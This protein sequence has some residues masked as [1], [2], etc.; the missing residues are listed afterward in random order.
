MKRS[1]WIEDLV[2]P[3][4]VATLTA[5]WVGL[6]VLWVARAGLPEVNYPPVSPLLLGLLVF[7]AALLTRVSLERSGGLGPARL[8]IVGAGLA[9]IA[10]ALWWTFR[11]AGIGAFLVALGDWGQYIS[12]VLM[13]LLAC[14]FMWWQGIQLAVANWPQ[15][16]LER[17]FGVGVIGLALL[18]AVNQ[19]NP[20]IA[21]GEAV[22][23]TVA[24]FGAGLG[25]LAL[26][27]FENA[28]SY[29]EGATGTRL[30]LNRY[31][32]ITIASVIG[33]ILAAGLVAA[34]LF[35]PGVYDSLGRATRGLLD[36]LT[37]VVAYAL[38]VL[39]ALV[40]LIVFPIMQALLHF[41]RPGAPDEIIE[42]SNSGT[43]TDQADQ[44]VQ[45]FADNPGLAAARQILFFVLLLVV[46]GLVLW[47]SVRR[48][49]QLNRRDSDEVRDSIATPELLWGQLKQFLN[50]RK[51]AAAEV[52]PYLALAGPGDDPRLIVRRAYQAMLEWARTVT[53]SRA[54]GQTPASYGEALARA[55]P[56]GRA[57]IHTLTGAYER[58]RYGAEPP[59]L[60]EARTA[61]G[62]LNELQALQT[63]ASNG[64]K[65]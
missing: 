14:A 26:V 36:G 62:A 50:R 17:S 39:A 43:V 46:V 13:A 32:L 23:T 64:S 57:A 59:S 56:Q 11:F 49:G 19:S 60:D 30:A 20:L 29:H 34:T 58:A 25:A 52:V 28:R 47:W 8:L 53:Q 54:A 38:A 18:F 1:N 22:S 21:P 31:W 12:P 44:A 2:F 42:F 35:S 15:Q 27:S 16:F 37:F 63:Q 33:V 41:G 55:M 7:G 45:L 9:A 48:L 24:L 65:R 10:A 51:P 5:A 40:A 3:V 61:Q 4:A 6:W